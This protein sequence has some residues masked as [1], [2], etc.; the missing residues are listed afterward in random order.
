MKLAGGYVLHLD[1]MHDA[2]APALMTG[3]D[4]LSK[5]VLANVK[6][7]SE[8]ADH[9]I[10]FLRKVRADYGTPNA[11]V[12]DMGVG[13]LKAV[14]KVFPDTRDFICHFHFLRDIG[15]DLLEPSYAKL[16][17]HL[18]SHAIS[19]RLHALAR[20]TRQCLLGQNHECAMLA[21]SIKDAVAPANSE[22]TAIV[23]CYS[24]TLWLLHGKH[25]GDGYGFP[26]DRP[27]LSFTHRLLDLHQ[28]LPKL[29]KLLVT[30]EKPCVDQS[31]CKLAR[32]ILNIANDPALNEA[33]EELRW[34]SLVFE[35]LRGAMRIAQ[36]GCGNGLNDEGGGYLYH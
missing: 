33:V 12:H 30:D 28:V 27:L 35:H 21:R 23:S 1:A 13:I 9:I 17:K 22:L 4:S 11:C 14:A 19:S 24:L 8:H 5:I 15:K 32:E 2:D 29:L 25:S 34:R 31:I 7:P 36:P 16:R 20:E 10:P 3:I 26:F 18:R 6:L